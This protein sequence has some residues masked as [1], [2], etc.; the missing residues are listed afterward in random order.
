MTLLSP[1]IKGGASAALQNSQFAEKLRDP[2]MRRN[3]SLI[4]QN[5]IYW[6]AQP[7]VSGP[8]YLGIIVF[9]LAL[10]GMVYLKGPLKW[11]LAGVT[12]LALMLSWGKNFMGLTDFFLDYLPGYNKFRAVTI[13][14]A[15]VE[16]TIPLLGVL[17]LNQLFKRREEIK[18]NIK[19]LFVTSGSLLGILI[20]LSFTGLG[21]GYLSPEEKDMAYS[22][23]QYIESRKAD[24]RQRIKED[25]RILQQNGIDPSNKAQIESLIAQNVPSVN[26]IN[27]QL[28]GG[29]FSF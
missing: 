16:L 17:F 5:N 21:D 2:E 27:K 13:I 20:L 3:A 8:V 10:L 4:G 19:P 14:L 24:I 15:V 25:P 18:N 26:Q 22:P 29:Q 7:F 28:C 9:F 1:N 23:E 12:I 6:G 11:T